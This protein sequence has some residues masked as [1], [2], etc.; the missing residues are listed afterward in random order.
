M[1]TDYTD[2]TLTQVDPAHNGG[3]TVSAGGTCFY[4]P[5]TYTPPKPGMVARVFGAFGSPIRGIILDGGAVFYRN[6]EDQKRWLLAEAVIADRKK[7]KGYL[8]ESESLKVKRESLPLAFRARLGLLELRSPEF[9]RLEAYE[10]F[11]C[12]EAVRFANALKTPEAIAAWRKLP[13]EEQKNLASDGHSVNTFGAACSLASIYLQQPAA[14]I[15]VH[16]SLV[17]LVGCK[18]YGCHGDW[19]RNYSLEPAEV[20]HA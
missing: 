8:A 5:A 16:G 14:V 1:D 2:Y 17:G 11:C 20:A 9:W 6:L 3:H 4:V 15:R 12:R 19:W 13:W 7:R 10:L 18:A